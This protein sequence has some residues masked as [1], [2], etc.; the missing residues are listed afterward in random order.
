MAIVRRRFLHLIAGVSVAP[1]GT[2]RFAEAQETA[3]PVR[4]ATGLLAT[5]QSTA[6]LGAELGVFKKYGIDMSLPAIA[7]GGP[8]SAPLGPDRLRFLL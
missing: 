2:V 7:V 1:M 6:W 5:W 8:W 3:R 4:A